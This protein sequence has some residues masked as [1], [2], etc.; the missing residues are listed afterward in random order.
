MKLIRFERVKLQKFDMS[1]EGHC[2]FI[3]RNVFGWCVKRQKFVWH[4]SRRGHTF[5]KGS[6]LGNPGGTLF[7]WNW[8]LENFT[9]YPVKRSLG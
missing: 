4:I 2:G 5:A 7:F 9:K 1:F 8:Q 3:Q 6:W